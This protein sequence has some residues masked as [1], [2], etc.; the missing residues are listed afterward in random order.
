MID[1]VAYQVWM[2]ILKLFMFWM[3]YDVDQWPTNLVSFGQFEAIGHIFC[4]LFYI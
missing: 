3:A 2:D 4:N 1:M